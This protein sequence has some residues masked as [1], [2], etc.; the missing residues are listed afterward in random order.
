MAFGGADAT[1]QTTS[2]LK[3]ETLEVDTATSL[4]PIG[5]N[6]NISA[7]GSCPVVIMVGQVSWGTVVKFKTHTTY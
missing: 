4:A 1:Y 3:M 6:V 7:S 2:K 5:S